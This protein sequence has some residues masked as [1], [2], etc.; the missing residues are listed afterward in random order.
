MAKFNLIG[1]GWL[2]QNKKGDEYV[3]VVFREDVKAGEVV[4]MWRN[5]NKHGERAPDYRLYAPEKQGP[6]G[7]TE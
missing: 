5:G 6:T 7:R 1:G 3:K 2:N 4:V